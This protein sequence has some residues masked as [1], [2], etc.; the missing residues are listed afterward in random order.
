MLSENCVWTAPVCVDYISAPGEELPGTLQKGILWKDPPKCL[1]KSTL[2]GHLGS[3]AEHLGPKAPERVAKR[4]R[5]EG[6]MTTK[7][8]KFIKNIDPACPCGFRHPPG[9]PKAC[10]LT[11]NLIA[12]TKN[13][14]TKT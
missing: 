14:K 5:K 8:R 10:F 3:K 11:Q 6:Q 7:S 12:T 2:G 4:A 9:E 13:L 1:P